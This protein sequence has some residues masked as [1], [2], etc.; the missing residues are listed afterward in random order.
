MK[1]IIM[2]KL[3]E[4]TREPF[5]VEVENKIRDYI[6]SNDLKPGDSLPGEIEIAAMMNISRN[7]VRE[8]LSGLRRI[9]LIE[10]KKKRGIIIK[11]IDPF[12][13]LKTC[14]P[15]FPTNARYIEDFSHLRCILEAGAIEQAILRSTKESLNEI[16]EMAKLYGEQVK[17]GFKGPKIDSAD[18]SF[19]MAILKAANNDFLLKMSDIIIKYFETIYRNII[20][21]DMSD[22]EKTDQEHKMIVEAIKQKDL[23]K[24]LELIKHHLEK[25][26][27]TS[28]NSEI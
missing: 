25:K 4:I 6:L 5:A 9:G 21:Q 16:E 2:K 15:F 3:Q 14:I 20:E 11:E 19:H 22:L 27:L 12:Q 8:A 10:S 1:V 18:I 26:L 24:S 7:V 13:V 17:K 28:K 23:N